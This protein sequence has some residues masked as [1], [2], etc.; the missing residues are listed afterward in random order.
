MSKRWRL[1]KQAK[2]AKGS[3][4]RLTSSARRVTPVS[5]SKRPRYLK[6]GGG[7]GGHSGGPRTSKLSAQWRKYANRTGGRH[8]KPVPTKIAKQWNAHAHQIKTAP[9]QPIGNR[10][11][12]TGRAPAKNA[13]KHYQDHGT[14]FQSQNAVHYYKQTKHFLHNPPKG[15]LTKVRP[16]SGEIVRYHPGSNTFAVMTKRGIPKTM[17]KP[18]PNKHGYK[19]GLDYFHAQ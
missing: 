18:D 19:T 1:A 4:P 15:T 5:I 11:I 2:E 10:G 8:A 13:Y 16:N 7:T 6:N 3:G 12:W 14:Q 9:F 17:F